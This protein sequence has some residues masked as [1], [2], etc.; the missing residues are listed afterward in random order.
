M[1]N[2]IGGIDTCLLNEISDELFRKKIFQFR[3]VDIII[4]NLEDTHK[5]FNILY[6]F[7]QSFFIFNYK[8]NIIY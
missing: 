7:L 2:N 4:C 8:R 6:I 1:I 5:Y 3:V